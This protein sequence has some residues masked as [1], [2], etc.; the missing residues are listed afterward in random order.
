[1]GRFTPAVVAGVQAGRG[2]VWVVG[3]AERTSITP[4][5]ALLDVMSSAGPQGTGWR[6]RSRRR[7]ATGLA[8]GSPGSRSSAHIVGPDATVKF[9]HNHGPD[10][11][12]THHA[13]GTA[14][15]GHRR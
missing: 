10:V 11:R 7:D 8:G 2:G 15:R 14:G 13:S 6:P 5:G 3:P 9:R 4:T 1:M 12:R